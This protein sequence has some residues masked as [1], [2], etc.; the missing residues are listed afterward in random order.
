MDKL[1]SDKL[2]DYYMRYFELH[3][4]QRMQVINYYIWIEIVLIGAYFTLLINNTSLIWGLRTVSIVITLFAVIFFLL[5]RR[6]VFLI[7]KTE[8]CIMKIE[9]QLD[10]DEY[11][12]LTKIENNTSKCFIRNTYSRVFFCVFFLTLV[13]GLNLIYH[14]FVLYSYNG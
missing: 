3:A 7:K 5:D 12:L 2:L 13:F 6:T 11:K 4:N 1:S 8:Q 14:A 9:S 10:N